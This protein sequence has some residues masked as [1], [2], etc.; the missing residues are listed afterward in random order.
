MNLKLKNYPFW[1][2]CLCFAFGVFLSQ[3]ITGY[4]V[5]KIG[6]TLIV[7]VLSF[8]TKTKNRIFLVSIYCL[9]TLLGILKS[10]ISLPKHNKNHITNLVKN[11]IP[12]AFTFKITEQ[13]KTSAKAHKYIGN[14]T[15]YDKSIVTGK[16]LVTSPSTDSL[17]KIGD[18]FLT[19]A[20]LNPLQKTGNPYA[21]E[22]S[23]YLKNKDV[24]FKVWLPENQ[25]LA[26]S[27]IHI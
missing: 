18:H 11:N 2:C 14:L 24:Y 9:F 5:L 27:L 23:E 25:L 10:E 17:L 26:L 3:F 12:K 1:I 15:T 13:L 19:Y 21:F 7:T 22:Y 4:L 20:K 8:V 6:V 16:I